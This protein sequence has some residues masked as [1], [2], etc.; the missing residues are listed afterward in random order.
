VTNAKEVPD[1]ELFAPFLQVTRVATFEKALQV[2]N[3]T[4]FGLSGGLVCDDPARW[5]EAQNT[6]RAG[7]LNWNRPTTGASGAMPFGG[8]GLSGDGRPSGYYAADYCAWPVARQ[9]AD[10]ATRLPAPGLS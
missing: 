6:L 4:R 10:K 8:P 3:D 2:A 1:E 9:E 5:E 7:V